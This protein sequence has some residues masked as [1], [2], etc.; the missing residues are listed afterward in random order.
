MSVGPTGPAV[1]V[2]L[3]GFTRLFGGDLRRVLDVARAADDAGVDQLVLPDHVVMGPRT[4]RYPFGRFPYGPEE[5]WPE[6]MT[7]LAAIAG[8]TERVRLATGILITPLRPA[9]VLAKTAATLDV[10]SGGRLDLGVGVGWQPEE[11]EA[12]GVPWAGRFSRLDDQLR[13]CRALWTEPPP[14]EFGSETVSFGPTW[15][16]PR[17]V[18]PGG[19]PLWLGMAATERTVAR[20]AELGAGW[21]PIHTTSHERLVDGIVRLRAAFETAGR[22]PRTLGVRAAARPVLRDDGRLDGP[23]TVAAT[24]TLTASGVTIASYGLG[25]HVRDASDVERFV[26]DLG[27]AF[28]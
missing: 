24:E 20:V 3:S 2:T 25:R 11:Y 7:L 21:L 9:T 22:D 5:P 12:G 10:V 15:C 4:D 14:V 16:E 17:P 19:V 13:A 18:Q 27:H 23:A 6:P 1:S 26:T 28:A 8:V